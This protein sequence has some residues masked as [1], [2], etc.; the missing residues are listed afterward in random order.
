MRQFYLLLF[1]IVGH[2]S[3]G[4]KISIVFESSLGAID[5]REESSTIPKIEIKNLKFYV[6]Q[7]TFLFKDKLVFYDQAY[8]LLDA[9]DIA[10]MSLSLE[11]PNRLKYDEWRFTLGVDSATNDSGVQGGSLD[12]TKGMYWSWQSGYINFKLEGAFLRLK[13]TQEFQYHLGG[14]LKEEQSAQRISFKCHNERNFLVHLNLEALLL[15]VI[16][17][18]TDQLMSPGQDAVRLMSI[19]QK[20]FSLKE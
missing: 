7:I 18:K 15:E 3:F 4:Q 17:S 6:G 5:L 10:S 9:N 20:S 19:L 1:L 2:T 8:Y 11:I 14:F 12:P 16:E 13:E